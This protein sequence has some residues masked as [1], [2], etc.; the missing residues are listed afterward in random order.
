TQRR[1]AILHGMIAAFDFF[2][3]VPQE[4]WWDNP[5]TV[6]VEFQRGLYRRVSQSYRELASHYNFAAVFCIPSRGIEK[7]HVEGRV[8]W[9]ERE[10]ATPVP[11]VGNLEE[12]NALLRGRCLEDRRRVATG[13]TATIGARFEQDR[14]E[15]ASLPLRRF[16]PCITREARADKYQTVRFDRVTYS[17]PR[18][19]AFQNVTVKAFVNHVEIVWRNT[20]VAYHERS[21]EPGTPMLDPRHHLVTL[22]RKPACLDHAP[23]YRD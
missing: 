12:L 10:W 17:V 1:E 2:E 15:A 13:P 9:L 21:Y 6:A 22:S 14:S 16:E 4:A 3:C 7:P 11:R 5:K 18:N 20:V 23:V 8:K 19:V